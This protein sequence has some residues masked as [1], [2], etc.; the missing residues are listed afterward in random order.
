MPRQL[1][2]QRIRHIILVQINSHA[3][4]TP[5]IDFARSMR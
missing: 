4:E 3:C 5:A 1:I 2:A